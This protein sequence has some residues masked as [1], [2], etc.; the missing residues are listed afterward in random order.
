MKKIIYVAFVLLFS[1]ELYA[2]EKFWDEV[3]KGKAAQFNGKEIT[4]SGILEEINLRIRA[5]DNYYLIRLKDPDSDKFVGIRLY[6]IWKLKRV[7]YFKCKER[8]RF[9]LTAKFRAKVK[10]SM[11]GE[12]IIVDE[13]D[14]MKCNGKEMI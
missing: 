6:S 4:V 12:M 14:S 8:M 1:V 13:N 11:I 7:N 3:R 5:R 2:T 9:L 10:K